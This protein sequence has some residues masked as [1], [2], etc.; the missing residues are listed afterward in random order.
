MGYKIDAGAWNSIFAV[1]S[2]VVDKHLK[3]L[4]KEQLKV[5][6]FLLRHS[7]ESYAA[8]DIANSAG[9][10]NEDV[11]ES[12]E[13]LLQMKLLKETSNA[14]IPASLTEP[15][16]EVSANNKPSSKDVP[17]KKR[18]VKPDSTYVARRVKESADMKYLMQEAENT[19]GKTV[20]P[21]LSSVLVAM[22]D[23]YGLPVEIIVMIIHYTKSIGK[24][25]TGY[26][27]SVGKNWS[28]EGIDNIKAAEQKLHELDERQQAWKKLE[29][30]LGIFHRAPSPKEEEFSF[31]WIKEWRMHDE[32]ITE[33]YNRC[34][35]KTGKLSMSYINRILERWREKNYTSVA[36]IDKAEKKKS[37]KSKSYDIDEFENTSFFMPL[38]D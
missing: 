6:L 5:L 21:A 2:E 3:L 25:S 1:P 11:E 26:I 7:G 8:E 33:A 35:D 20:S 37:E 9:V 22:N 36:E 28:E 14:L 23:D 19:L 30:I 29:N 24:T 34:I 15:V 13:F 12:I 18:L 31:R 17:E 4:S 27:D 38:G 32:L 16:I 10:K